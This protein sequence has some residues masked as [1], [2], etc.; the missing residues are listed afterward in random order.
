MAEKRYDINEISTMTAMTTRTLRTYLK[1]GILT[2]TKENGKWMFSEQDIRKFFDS[3]YV[4]QGLQ[5]KNHAIVADFVRNLKKE[6]SSA[7]LIYDVPG[8]EE[9]QKE[10]CRK[11]L[12][13]IN[14]NYRENEEN[15]QFSYYYDKDAKMGRFVLKGNP[16][17]AAGFLALLRN[18]LLQQ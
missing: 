14:E 16:Q 11:V 17:I 3:D 2:G 8:E 12:N 13:Y 6:E 4:K 7:C 10:L 1:Q 15:N 9:T 5:I 18:S